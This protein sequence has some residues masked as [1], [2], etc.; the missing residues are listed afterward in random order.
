M[1]TRAELFCKESLNFRRESESEKEE[2]NAIRKKKKRR[3]RRLNG[4]V[5]KTIIMV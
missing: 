2:A 4:L 3:K 1:G 5:L